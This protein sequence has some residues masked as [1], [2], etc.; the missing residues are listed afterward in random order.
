MNLTKYV[1][2]HSHITDDRYE[3]VGLVV[4]RAKEAGVEQ[5]ICSAY[6]FY[7]SLEAI[8]LSQKYDNVF[9]NVGIH[10]ENTN[11][12]EEDTLILIEE[13][14]KEEKVVA[15]GE[16]GLDFHR[17]GFNKELQKKY[18]KSQIELANRVKK[19]IVVHSREAMGE[20]IEILKNNP[21]CKESVIHCFSGSV[22]SA[23]ILLDLGFSFS[24]G[25][26]VTF[27]NAKKLKE[28]VKMVPL[29]RIL[30]ETDCPYL[31]PVPDRGKRNDSRKLI[32]VADAV[33]GLKG[34]TTEEVIRITEENA[35][36]FYRLERRQ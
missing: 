34:I 12:I 17:E 20:T 5:M 14:A 6:N 30:L 25:G 19:P 9:A 33:A 3:D 32:H 8:K 23:K 13:L 7:S 11:E 26:V 2:V 22:E 1:D 24:I 18:F 15:I 21:V 16:I 35:A 29:E 4:E 28:V 31:A 36:A 27:K 10:P